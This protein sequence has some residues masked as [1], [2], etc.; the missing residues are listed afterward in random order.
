MS[1]NNISNDSNKSFLNSGISDAQQNDSKVIGRFFL[2]V[3]KPFQIFLETWEK[4]SIFSN[5][6]IDKYYKKSEW[7]FG[8]L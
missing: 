6:L 2:T 8:S 1:E 4:T 3:S 5:K 7:V